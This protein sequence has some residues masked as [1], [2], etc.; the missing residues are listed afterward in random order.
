MNDVLHAL[1]VA[2]DFLAAVDIV[3]VEE[4]AVL[5][6]L[7]RKRLE[8]APVPV[9][10][11]R[12]SSE[13]TVDRPLYVL[14]NEFL[15]ALPIH[16]FVKTDRGWCERMVTVNEA[17]NLDFALA[18]DPTPIAPTAE[19]ANDQTGIVYEISPAAQ[20]L[21]EEMSRAIAAQ[22][23]AALFIDYGHDESGF[24]DTLQA[25][26]QH[27]PADV[28]RAPGGA[29]LSAHVD[30][31]AITRAVCTAPVRV[32]GPTSQGDFLQA[33]GIEARGAALIGKNP[34]AAAEVA[35]AIERLTAASQ[36]GTLFKALAIGPRD[37]PPLPGF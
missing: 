23:G 6:T 27:M 10:W 37:Q 29:D 16:Q 8:D 21:A 19:R 31:A 22:G 35:E 12:Q 4:S 9:R 30:F 5:R 18:P 11:V 17:G 32:Y 25:V 3:L 33:L 13:I 2:P 14:A 20:A 15:D 7:Q 26:H 1:R 34:A 28:L 24:G 36:M